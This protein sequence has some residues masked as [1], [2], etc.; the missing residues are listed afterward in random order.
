MA[1]PI[2]QNIVRAVQ[3]HLDTL[4]DFS[5]IIGR[6][7]QL[8]ARFGQPGRYEAEY[9]KTEEPR[10]AQSLAWLEKFEAAAWEEGVD[11]HTVYADCGGY[12]APPEPSTAAR[13]WRDSWKPKRAPQRHAEHE[14]PYHE[15]P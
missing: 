15:V 11:P 6:L 5:D 14:E 3:R 7:R 13:E 1:T 4:Q 9:R 12:S 10:V 2:P 8:E